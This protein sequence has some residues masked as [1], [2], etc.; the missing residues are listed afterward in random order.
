MQT[1]SRDAIADLKIQIGPYQCEESGLWS[2]GVAMEIVFVGRK[3]SDLCR[4]RE[5]I[6]I[7]AA[8]GLSEGTEWHWLVERWAVVEMRDGK[9]L[10]MEDTDKG[11]RITV[12]IE[13]DRGYFDDQTIT[14]EEILEATLWFKNLV[15]LF[16]T[17][18]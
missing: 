9:V 15:R 5:V 7:L 17:M 16:L 13:V 8:D 4:S 10:R 12:L 1:L 18:H 6:C 14:E 3:T 11:C 2:N